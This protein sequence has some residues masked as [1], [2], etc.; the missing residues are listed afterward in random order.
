M[1]D[2][3][4]PHETHE[5]LPEG[6]LLDRHRWVRLIWRKVIVRAIYDYVLWRDDPKIAKRHW[7]EDARKWLFEE[8]ELNNS[9]SSVC[10]WAGVD[11][12][13]VRYYA[14]IATKADVKKLEHIER[15]QRD[16]REQKLDLHVLL[17]LETAAS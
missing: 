4:F 8:S 13:K 14:R 11:I 3:Y 1:S 5:E 16:L 2:S 17:L 15:E 7:A 10:F 12:E 6:V 9:L